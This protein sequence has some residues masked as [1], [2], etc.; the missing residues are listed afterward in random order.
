MGNAGIRLSVFPH[1]YK[2]GTVIPEEGFETETF[3]DV[4]LMLV[5]GTNE[6]SLFIASDERFA[7]DFNSGDLFQDEQK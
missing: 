4:P 3:N 6:F 7:E 1:L 2:D 5:T